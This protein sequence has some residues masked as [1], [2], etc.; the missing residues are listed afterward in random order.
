MAGAVR[1][2]DSACADSGWVGA[3]RGFLCSVVFSSSLLTP[4]AVHGAVVTCRNPPPA[5]GAMSDGSR[6]VES[7]FSTSTDSFFHSQQW[8]TAQSVPVRSWL[9]GPEQPNSPLGFAPCLQ[10]L[11]FFL[12]AFLFQLFLCSRAG[13]HPPALSLAFNPFP[14][15]KQN[16]DASQTSSPALT[17][18][19]SSGSSLQ[20]CR[21]SLWGWHQ[22]LG[23]AVERFHY[24]GRLR[25]IVL[26]A[27]LSIVLFL[28]SHPRQQS[29]KD[30]PQGE[31]CSFIGLKLA[32]ATMRIQIELSSS[33]KS[34]SVLSW[35]EVRK[36]IVRLFLLSLGGNGSF[37]SIKDAVTCLQHHVGYDLSRTRNFCQLILPCSGARRCASC[38]RSL[39]PLPLPGMLHQQ[40]PASP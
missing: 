5:A 14:R 3:A 35:F 39:Q 38:P 21:A 32:V 6:Q 27:V 23:E 19:S 13:I 8:K 7:P 36:R 15:V 33:R 26:F 34:V 24:K 37:L 10:C 2:C 4:F 9:L 40:L 22:S 11:S 18:R 12:Y 20:C 17:E 31:R 30:K 1:S 29:G 16:R 28:S 25:Q